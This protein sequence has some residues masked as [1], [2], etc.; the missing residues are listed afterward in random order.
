MASPAMRGEG[1][2]T[3]QASHDANTQHA[4]Y[5]RCA[6]VAHRIRRARHRVVAYLAA[7]TLGV[8]PALAGCGQLQVS[9]VTGTPEGPTI[10]I[11][12]AADE[13]G[14]GYWHDGGY[15]G[16][17]VDVATYVAKQ[18][19]YSS[20]QIIFKQVRP[21]TRAR[22]LAESTVDMVVAGYA[23]NGERE[24]E[25]DFAGPY[26]TVGRDLLIRD[27]DVDKI[28]RVADMS[29]RAACVVDPDAAQAL[30]VAAPG[31][32]VRERDSYPQCV[33]ALMI[34]EADAVAA[35]DAVLSG[36]IEDKG[37]G[38]LSLVGDQYGEVDYGI[39][40]KDGNAQLAGKISAALDKMKDDGT[41]A[42]LLD[43]M[44]EETGYQG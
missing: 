6:C 31:V 16:F 21:S 15:S 36:L 10:A 5:M 11:G 38:Y 3:H 34:G 19:G 7:L 1:D 25:A 18:L 13:P 23:M 14:M 35:D 39:A 8:V 40:V 30:A 41:Y 9:T 20:K 4:R 29:G 32:Q 44:R 27:D 2:M 17:E 26:L 33:T 37:N 42:T 12:V 43:R 24:S 22:M 28:S